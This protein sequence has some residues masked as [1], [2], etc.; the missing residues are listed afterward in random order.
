MVVPEDGVA[1]FAF[2]RPGEMF[3]LNEGKMW[4][5][6]VAGETVGDILGVV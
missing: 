6:R 4:V 5:V 2:G 3:L 1:N